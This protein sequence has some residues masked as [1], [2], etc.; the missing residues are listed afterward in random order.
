MC[1]AYLTLGATDWA[2]DAV[3]EG[4]TE[5]AIDGAMEGAWLVCEGVGEAGGDMSIGVAGL[6]PPPWLDGL[7]IPRIQ[8]GINK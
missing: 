1:S 6:L 2:T 4:A 3:S 5:G 8:E 7:R